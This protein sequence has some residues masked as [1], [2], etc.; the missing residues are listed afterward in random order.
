VGDLP[1][2]AHRS[3]LDTLASS[4]SC[5]RTKGMYIRPQARGTGLAA[6]LVQ[7]AVAHARPLSEQVCL[8]LVTSND[9]ARRLYSAAGFQE[10]GFERRALKVGSEYY[11][12]GLVV[13]PLN[14][15]PEGATGD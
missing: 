4:G 5:H 1:R 15:L 6:A 7:R 13:L 10:F 9:A 2:A 14:P 11:H 12:D 8:A 3:G